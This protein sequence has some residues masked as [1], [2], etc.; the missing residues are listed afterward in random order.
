MH[1]I[2]HIYRREKAKT[3]AGTMFIEGGVRVM[4]FQQY[5]S[6]IVVVNFIGGGKRSTWRKPPTCCKSLTN[7]INCCIKYALPE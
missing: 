4:V 6:Y 1:A 3:V 2:T 5:F 7:L